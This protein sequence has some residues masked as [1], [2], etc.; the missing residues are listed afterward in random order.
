MFFHGN[1]ATQKRQNQLITTNN[2]QGIM[3]HQTRF[4][5]QSN[6]QLFQFF[7]SGAKDITSSHLWLMFRRDNLMVVC[8]V[9]AESY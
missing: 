2:T 8:L 3:N 7:A 4:H 5:Q 1:G 6:P 9:G